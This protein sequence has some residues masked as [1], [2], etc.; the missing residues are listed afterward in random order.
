MTNKHLFLLLLAAFFAPLAM[1]AQS[2]LT[3]HDGTET[4]ERVPIF[5]WHANVDQQS[6]L[7]YPASELADMSGKVLTQMVF[8]WQQGQYGDDYSVGTWTISLGET[9]ATA[10]NGGFD[11]T[12]PLTEVFT[13]VLDEAGGLFNTTDHTLTIAFDEEYAYQ[14]GNLLVQFAHTGTGEDMDYRFIGQSMDEATSYLCCIENGN[15]YIDEPNNFLPKVTFTYQEPS[16]CPKPTNLAVS[17]TEGDPTAT[18][19]WTS[20]ATNFNIDVNGTITAVMGNTYT[21]A[22]SLLTTYTIK[23][24]ADCGNELSFWTKAISFFSGCGIIPIPYSY[25]FEDASDIDCWTIITT[26]YNGEYT[27]IY[28]DED[29][30]DY[31]HTGSHSFRFYYTTEPGQYLISPELGGIGNGLRV[32]FWY[33]EEDE[34][35]TETFQ[36]GYS[37]TDNDP[38]SFTWG[39][40]ITA[41]TSYQQFKA[42]Y[43]ADTK[44][45]AVKHTSDDQWNLYFDDFLFEESP[46][47]IEPTGV[48][49]ADVTTNSATISWTAGGSE[50]A[51]DI[52]VTADATI[53]PDDNTTPTV[54]NANNNSYSLSNLSAGTIY[55]VYVRAICSGTEVSDWSLPATFATICNP[56]ALP[57]S[58]NFNNF[59]GPG[60][61]VCWNSIFEGSDFCGIQQFSENNSSLMIFIDPSSGPNSSATAVL[62][63]IDENYPLNGYQISFDAGKLYSY[64]HEKLD[65]GIMTDPADPTTFTLV[66]EVDIIDIVFNGGFGTYTVYFNNYTGN[67]HYIA[68][69]GNNINSEGFNVLI[70]N[71][72][73][74]EAPSCISPTGLAA[75]A[76][77]DSADLSWTDNNSEASWTL[78]WKERGAEAYTEVPDVTDNPYTLSNLSAATAYEFY[79]V[80]NCSETDHSDP[81]AVYSFSTDCNAF[82]LP[83]S[84]DF[85]NLAAGQGVP[86]CWNTIIEGS[87]NNCSINPFYDE[88]NNVL[89]ISINQPYGSAKAA[90]V[91]PEID[92]PLSQCQ[93]SFDASYRSDNESTTEKHLVIFVLS[94]PNDLE[95]GDVF[96]SVTINDHYPNFGRYTVPFGNY[97]GDGQYI[98]LVCLG[99][100]S[101]GESDPYVVSIDNIV[102]SEASSSTDCDPIT[103]PWGEDF[104]DLVGEDLPACWDNIIDGST[105]CSI[106]PFSGDDNNGLVISING[107]SLQNSVTVVL[108]EVDASYPLNQCQISFDAGYINENTTGEQ[109]I[110]VIMSDPNDLQTAEMIGF[111]AIT[112]AYPNIGRHTVRFNDYD[113]NG[114]Y[115]ALGCLG[116]GPFGGSDSYAVFIDNIEVT[117][118]PSC[119]PPAN[120]A[121][122]NITGSSAQLAWTVNGEETAWDIF[123][124]T[125]ASVQPDDST[126]PTVAATA[127]N[128]YSLTGLDPL[129]TYYVYVRVLCGD[130]GN[131][132]WSNRATFTTKCATTTVDADHPY[133]QDFNDETFP[134]ECWELGGDPFSNWYQ[135]VQGYAYTE[136]N[137]TYLYMP[138]LHIDA[139]NAVLTFKTKERDIEYYTGGSENDGGLSIVKVS[140]NGGGTWTQLWCPTYD[141]LTTDFRTVTLSLYD[142]VGQDILIA[143]EHQGHHGWTI[144]DVEVKAEP[145][146]T[147]HK[148]IAAWG[149]GDGW[150]LIASPLANEVNPTNV[151]NMTANQFDLYRFNQSADDEWENYKNH[152]FMLQPGQGYLYA[153][154]QDVELVFT[155]IPY[156]EDGVIDLV[157]DDQLTDGDA[158]K[159]LNLVGNPFNERAYVDR[160]FYV[161]NDGREIIAATQAERNYVE[162]MEGIFVYSQNP[163]DLTVTFST[164]APDG[165]KGALVMNVGQGNVIDRAIIRF[166]GNNMPKFQLFKNSTKLAIAQNDS[167]YAV[168]SAGNEGEMPVNF[169]AE[170]NGTYSLRFTSEEV[171]FSYL[172]LIDNMTGNDIDLLQTPSYSFNARTTDYESRFKLV[173]AAGSSTG[174]DTF[175]FYSDGNLVINNE[176]NATLQVIDVNGRILSSEEINGSVSKAIHQPAGVYMLRLINGEDVKVQK[177]VID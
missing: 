101:F 166:G 55:Y 27:G 30:E 25:G 83:W 114:Q 119:L 76:T 144:D 137:P 127:D 118:L 33:R 29:D 11:T 160:D 172:H 59:A 126:T 57:W 106:A 84:E 171:S 117:E 2:T 4:S 6:Q 133:T 104:N 9:T 64:T 44:Y 94:D 143:F 10:F 102:V 75:D 140:T 13:G 3:V 54:A 1:N 20:E 58:E 43:P 91:L 149:E 112:D 130:D 77:F 14:G 128:P 92:A 161:M 62:P 153:N 80:A 78:Y 74:S 17:Y 123:V 95:T 146:A 86:A 38:D 52:Y 28:E 24:Q 37:T 107:S 98:A 89:E 40:E 85:N 90:V 152:G 168:V 124:T 47:C 120:L 26:G 60:M 5:S 81:S 110:I 138:F 99:G 159:G 148:T 103:L 145:L 141:E 177:I 35:Y 34:Y 7:I 162:P 23:V 142:Y 56:I 68:I 19:T 88:V 16:A 12:T 175:A 66:E 82:T 132:E 165:A 122:S 147:F 158:M 157:Y 174:S 36:V 69:R 51:W 129:T 105:S 31:A 170:K 131:T 173:F 50:T 93:I 111:V 134:P 87:M 100:S 136:Y 65:I 53:V 113:G 71:I 15:A 21:F 115:I 135:T 73:V 155:G 70:D 63:E 8:Y 176:G 156:N 61:P 72:V 97:T 151:T 67:G 109:L 154:S 163:N 18:V 49:V 150:Y 39:D 125:D 167:E 108:P 22:V 45:V 139:N 116:G 79:V 48:Q 41:T 121:A 42:N 46:S 169:K 96:T 32:K 164:I